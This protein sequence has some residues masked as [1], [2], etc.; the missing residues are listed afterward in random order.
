MKNILF[1]GV[2]SGSMLSNAGLAV[3]RVV[4][5]ISIAF[6]H[7][8]GKLPP[9]AGFVK[10]VAG[11]NFPLPEAFAWAAGMSEFVG[12]LLLAVGLMTR[13]A[14]ITLAI[15]MAVALFGYHSGDA[16]RE[17]ELAMLYGVTSL[18]FAGMGSGRFGLDRIVNRM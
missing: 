6:G 3:L 8:L 4:V 10:L 17:W 18:M 12:G 11:L 9:P 15:T 7:G 1:G 2:T 16:F 14:A 5:G 13:P